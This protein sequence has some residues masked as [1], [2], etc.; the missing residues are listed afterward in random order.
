MRL[1]L[2]FLIAIPSLIQA[3]L[4]KTTFK[5][6]GKVG[7]IKLQKAITITDKDTTIAYSI[8]KNPGMF[9]IY[10]VYTVV[11]NP[12]EIPE[13][14]EA[15]KSFQSE[16]KKPKAET[17][18]LS[19]RTKDSTIVSCSY[20]KL[21]GWDIMIIQNTN[22]QIEEVNQDI[23]KKTGIML[24]WFIQIDPYKLEGVIKLLNKIEYSEKN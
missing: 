16:I 21:T 15:L 4:S 9:D 8:S 19:Y 5:D 1:I 7:A 17:T 3:Q 20:V 11:L 13:V 6:V 10:A 18:V 22:K 2:L 23:Q 24:N 12:R 14:I